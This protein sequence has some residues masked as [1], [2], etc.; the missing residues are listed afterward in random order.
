MPEGK[1]SKKYPKNFREETVYNDNTTYP[2][3]RRHSPSDESHVYVDRAGAVD[4]KWVVPYNAYL[5]M[6]FNAHINVEVRD[7]VQGVKYM[8]KYV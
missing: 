6:R 8:F 3:Y 1:C 7:S 4:N 2:E 5:Y